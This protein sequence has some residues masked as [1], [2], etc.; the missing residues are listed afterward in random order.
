ME[1]PPSM[2]QNY[3]QGGIVCDKDVDIAEFENIFHYQQYI[4]IK[5]H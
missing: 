3:V 1:M 2:K 4:Q 5:I